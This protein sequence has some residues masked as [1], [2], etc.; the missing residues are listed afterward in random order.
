MATK[1]IC[2][3]CEK[4]Q[5]RG[6]FR[7]QYGF[8]AK[9]CKEDVRSQGRAEILVKKQLEMHGF[10]M[11]HNQSDPRTRARVA[12][13]RADFR[14]I[15]SGSVEYDIV[16]EVDEDAHRTRPPSREMERMLQIIEASGKRPHIF[17]RLNPDH[18]RDGIS[19]HPKA[20]TG[21][22]FVE[23]L[24]SRVDFMMERIDIRERNMARRKKAN[25][26]YQPPILYIEYLY[27]DTDATDSK[28][29]TVTPRQF[30]T[31]QDGRKRAQ[32]LA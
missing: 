21:Q 30:Q 32:T 8:C 4:T 18:Y 7:D 17:F 3:L 12:S 10:E 28:Y 16:I 2:P 22:E 29:R 26:N 24:R 31:I 27:Y 15:R 23:T 19:K 25:A 9:C 6:K 20:I 5:L 14:I 1:P 13:V 11:I